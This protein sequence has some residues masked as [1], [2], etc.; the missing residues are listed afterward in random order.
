MKASVIHWFCMSLLL[1]CIVST[2]PAAA[3]ELL[4]EGLEIQDRFEPG[5]GTAVGK[6]ARVA[7]DVILIHKSGEKGYRAAEGLDLFEDDTVVTLA[8]SHAAL[9]L[10]DGSFITLSPETRLILSKSV[11]SPEKNVR[12]TFINMILGKTRFVVQSLVA[13]R[14]SEF[15]V[16]TMTSVAGVRGSDFIIYATESATEITALADTEIEVL[17]LAALEATPLILTDFEQTRIR[18]GMPPEAARKL[19]ADEIDRLMREFRFQPTPADLA[20][21]TAAGAR[22]DTAAETPGGI[23]VDRGD[24]IHPDDARF[25]PETF[26]AAPLADYF[27]VRAALTGEEDIR[28][29]RNAISHHR[30]EEEVKSRLPDFPGTP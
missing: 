19:D 11:Y 14:R 15:K 20:A 9:R 27:R 4:P 23:L 17:S 18:Q 21:E 30:V 2:P 28:D 26:R 6:I 13:S 16:K 12:S 3:A 29:T 10:A 5:P 7:G 22:P 24:L 1:C 25:R 8:G